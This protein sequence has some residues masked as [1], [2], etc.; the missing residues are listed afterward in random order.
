MTRLG[1]VTFA[2][3][4]VGLLGLVMFIRGNGSTPPVPSP[5]VPLPV[6]A[7]PESIAAYG[8]VESLNENTAVGAP[9][10]GIVG[11]VHAAVWKNVKQGELLFT[12][13]D[14]ELRAQLTSLAA[15]QSVR[16]AELRRAKRQ[17]DRLLSLANINQAA[18]VRSELDKSEDDYLVAEANLAQAKAAI[19][20]K[21]LLLER[22]LVRAPVDG[23][24][25]QVNIRS[26]E[27]IALP[28]NVPPIILGSIDELQVRAEIDEQIS[29][30]FREG[31]RAVAYRKGDTKNP[32]DLSYLQIEPYVVPKKNL[33]GLSSE[34]VDTRVLQVLFK[35][36]KPKQYPVY[37]GQQVDLFIER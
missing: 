19:S 13:D 14:R 36:S 30:A 29:A 11:Q 27:G 17:R 3:S 7:F 22:Y 24:V 35:V 16:E 34:R 15:N 33:A 32:L 10:S 5:I 18:V 21:E 37:V 20:E 9:I 31:A 23:T 2:A 8:I 26:G 1:K 12:I 28:Q 4:L 25:L 6:S